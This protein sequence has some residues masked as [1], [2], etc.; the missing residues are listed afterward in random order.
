MTSF[1][2]KK[3][4]AESVPK[5]YA[6]EKKGRQKDGTWVLGNGAYF[7]SSGRSISLLE[8]NFVWISL[9]HLEL[10]LLPSSV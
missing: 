5:K 4:N 10:H 6:V 1:K 9:M 2:R 3:R 8:S 7:N